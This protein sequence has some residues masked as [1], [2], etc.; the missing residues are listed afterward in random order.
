MGLDKRTKSCFLLISTT[1]LWVWQSVQPTFDKILPFLDISD[2]GLHLKTAA[3]FRLHE[4]LDSTSIIIS[5]SEIIAMCVGVATMVSLYSLFWV[6]TEGSAQFWQSLAFILLATLTSVGYGMHAVCVIAQLHISQDNP[7]YALL[8][9]MHERWSHNMFQIGMF[10]L[11]LLVVWSEKPRS[12]KT[13][14]VRVKSLST[15]FSMIPCNCCTVLQS[16]LAI[17]TGLFMSVFANSTKTGNVAL[18]FYLSI[19]FSI[20]LFM[21]TRNYEFNKVLLLFGQYQILEFYLTVS[22]YG[23]PT[24]FIHAWFFM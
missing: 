15:A 8:D 5:L 24:L 17:V 1:L 7:L 3:S 16:L 23:L 13:T 14:T 12:L 18:V 10:G 19:C 9:F 22:M 2:D 21:K 4:I 6:C 11:F 20:Y